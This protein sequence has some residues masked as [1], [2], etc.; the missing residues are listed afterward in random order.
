LD[1]AFFQKEPYFNRLLDPAT[2]NTKPLFWSSSALGIIIL[3]LAGCQTE[4]QPRVV[5][6]ALNAD[7]ADW[8]LTVNG[9]NGRS[10]LSGST[11]T[12]ELTHLRL[13]QGDAMLLRLPQAQESSPAEKTTGWLWGYCRSNNVAVYF[14]R[15]PFPGLEMFSVQAYH[16]T[17]PYDN[18]FDL[19]NASFFCEG[20]LIGRSTNGFEEM[21]HQIARDHPKQIF[22]LGSFFDTSRSFPPD[23]APYDDHRDRLDMVLKAARTDFVELCPMP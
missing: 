13:R 2:M 20:R 16:W 17:A 18:P 7:S 23:P 8:R 10:S 12:Q 4:M 11:L 21:L 6:V 9:A 14:M 22:I 1:F 15:E 19:T 3:A 5:R